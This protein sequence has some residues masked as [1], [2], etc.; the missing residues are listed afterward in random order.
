MM[1]NKHIHQVVEV[2]RD[3]SNIATSV[4]ITLNLHNAT[5]QMIKLYN[6]ESGTEQ[7]QTYDGYED[8]SIVDSR[9]MVYNIPEADQTDIIPGHPHVHAEELAYQEKYHAWMDAAKISD[10]YITAQAELL[11]DY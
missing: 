8:H 7:T 3:E 6:D 2:I 1:T 5:K 9:S 11:G 4:N 10:E